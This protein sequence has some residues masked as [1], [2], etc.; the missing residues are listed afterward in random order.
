VKIL[1]EYKKKNDEWGDIVRG[2]VPIEVESF[3]GEA[4]LI[5]ALDIAFEMISYDIQ[6]AEDELTV[7]LQE[8]LK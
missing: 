1:Q 7:I 8:G 2:S 6:P 5:E 3:S 4:A